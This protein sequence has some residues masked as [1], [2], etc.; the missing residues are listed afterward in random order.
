MTFST[1]NMH[2]MKKVLWKEVGFLKD[3]LRTNTFTDKGKALATVFVL[4]LVVG[5]LY[6]VLNQSELLLQS[7]VLSESSLSLIKAKNGNKDSLFLCILMERMWIVPFLFLVSTTNLC[8][9]VVYGSIV[10]YGV[11][12]GALFAVAI[13]RYRILGVLFLLFCSMPQYLFYGVAIVLTFRLCKEQRKPD[14]K[15][16]LQLSVLEGIVLVGCLSESYVNY[17]MVEKIIKI[18][19]GV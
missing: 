18:F 1:P 16:F 8:L 11:S 7:D 12:F 4:S 19:I 15:F 2:T 9:W 17:Y 6:I 3:I 13:L 14:K 10:W 5:I